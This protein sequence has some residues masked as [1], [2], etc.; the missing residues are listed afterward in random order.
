MFVDIGGI[1]QWIEIETDDAANPILL[2]IH[3]GPGGTT[4]GASASWRPWRRHFTLVHWDQRGAGRTFAKNGPDG[5]GPMTFEQ[6][7]S[8][9]IEVAE[10]VRER[11]GGRDVFLLGH[12]WGAA[13]GVHMVRRRPEPFGA[14]VG[15]GQLVNFQRNEAANYERELAM[16][17]RAANPAALAELTAIGPPPHADLSAVG[18]LRKWG[19]ELTDGTGDAPQPRPPVRPDNMTPEDLQAMRAG[20]EFSTAVLFRDLCAVD[21]PAIGTTFT[22]PMFIFM[23]THD[24]WTPIALAEAYFHSIEA[25]RKAFVRFEGCHHFVHMNRPTDFLAALVTHLG[26]MRR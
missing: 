13:V 6:I 25:P 4:R 14:F 8:D 3:G 5:S 18:V 9:G 10:F 1:P 19:D 26:P 2:L 11:L 16:A 15:T 7:V 12:S 20:F 23:G 17:R 24:P 22:V 21:L